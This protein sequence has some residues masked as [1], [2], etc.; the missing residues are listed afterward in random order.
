MP[1]PSRI[2]TFVRIPQLFWGL[3]VILFILIPG[4][5]WGVSA[6]AQTPASFLRAI[7][8][9][10]LVSQLGDL[11]Y[12]DVTLDGYS[13]FPVTVLVSSEKAASDRSNVRL[14]VA[15]IESKLDWIVNRYINPDHINVSVATLGHQTVIL[16]GLR[17]NQTQEILL[18]VTEFDAQLAQ[19]SIPILAQEWVD[20]IQLALRR[21]WELRLPNARQQQFLQFAVTL[22][23]LFAISLSLFAVQRW[24][25]RLFKR[26]KQLI[27]PNLSAGESSDLLANHDA[28]TSEVIRDFQQTFA[29]KQRQ[30]LNFAIRRVLRL[31]QL[32]VWAY[33]SALLLSIFPE[34][35]IL[36]KSL[37]AFILKLIVIVVSM[38]LLARLCGFLLNRLLNAWAESAPLEPNE[39]QRASL[40]IPTLTGVIEGIITFAVWVI[41][42]ILLIDLQQIPINSILASLG[43]LGF[44]IG[45]VFQ[46]LLRD[47]MN[48]LFI[49]FKD[50]YAVGDT[51]SIAG[52]TGVVE[53]ITLRSTS[54]RG[55][56]GSLNTIP[57]GQITTV[58]NLTKDWSRVE[59]TVQ[60]AKDTDVSHA[61]QV[62]RQVADEMSHDPDWLPRIL[63][64]ACR[65]GV[66]QIGAN[67]TQVLMWIKTKRAAQWK[68][69]SEFR[70]RLKKAFE[71][72][73]IHM[74]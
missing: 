21:A 72:Q 56:G 66:S 38:L 8:P 1:R 74:S 32:S 5:V 41:G 20:I 59:L 12:A 9:N 19:K 28:D 68:V 14:R 16:A 2:R 26:R 40:R 52:V 70:Y 48:G 23:V 30:R 47:F 37:I 39:V 17:N 67:G 29:L 7:R 6:Q 24:I 49:I 36:G 53:N 25:Y 62:M 11:E 33:G 31:T 43:F 42:I 10:I 71:E 69:E 65:I 13:L 64:P 44:A 4:A 54:V 15:T 55:V 34:T 45:I 22:S 51:V 50:Y 60:V 57:H 73:G 35:Y 61:M 27:D 58:Q 46:N 3:V 18:T 63:D